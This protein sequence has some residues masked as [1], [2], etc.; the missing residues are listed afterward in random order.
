MRNRNF[1]NKE[2]EC[3]SLHRHFWSCTSVSLTSCPVWLVSGWTSFNERS[4][5]LFFYSPIL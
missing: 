1:S 3:Q 5:S 2:R 4:L